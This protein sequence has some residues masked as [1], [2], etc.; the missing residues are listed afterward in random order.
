VLKAL[1]PLMAEVVNRGFLRSGFKMGGGEGLRTEPA[2]QGSKH[3]AQGGMS[4]EERRWHGHA[5]APWGQEVDQT[6]EVCMSVRGE[7]E[8]ESGERQNP[9]EKAYTE[10]CTKGARV[11]CAG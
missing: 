9:V 10:E 4:G 6:S 2:S 8:G 11:D 1:T 7:R 3:V 5:W